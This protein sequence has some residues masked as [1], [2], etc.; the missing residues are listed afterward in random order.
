[1]IA[2][3]QGG[4]MSAIDDWDEAAERL[5]RA[6]TEWKGCRNKYGERNAKAEYFSAR[7]GFDEATE[8]LGWHRP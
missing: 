3:K 8:R 6:I 1:M 5:V 7:K 2:S 4:D